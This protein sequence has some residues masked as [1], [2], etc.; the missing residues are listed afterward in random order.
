MQRGAWDKVGEDMARVG[1]ESVGAGELQESGWVV[2]E[3]RD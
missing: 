2:G 3:G 1:L